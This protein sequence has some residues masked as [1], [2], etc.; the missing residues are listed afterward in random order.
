MKR[1]ATGRRKSAGRGGA[2]IHP[3]AAAASKQQQ[4]Q[5][6]CGGG[7]VYIV[8]THGT[9]DRCHRSAFRGHSE[10]NAGIRF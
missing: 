9:G 5:R 10:Y 1:D 6:C 2:P 4:Q 8:E 7:K 3:S